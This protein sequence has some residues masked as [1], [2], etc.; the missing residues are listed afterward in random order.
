MPGM[1]LVLRSKDYAAYHARLAAQFRPAVMRGVYA[2]AQR[3]I[4]YLVQRTRAAPPANPN[5]KGSGG[6]VNTGN[7]ARRWRAIRLPDGAEIRND[8]AYGSIIDPE[9]GRYGRRPGAKFPPKPDL[10]AWI[11]RRLLTTAKKPR[12]PSKPRNT[13]EQRRQAADAMR[14]RKAIRSGRALASFK[15]YGPVRPKGPSRRS[16]DLDKQAARL[17]FPIARAIARR[18]LLARRILHDVQPKNDI[19]DFVRAE[20]RRELEKE[21]SRR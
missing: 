1:A 20:V 9:R 12:R 8:A 5:G 6:A 15:K 17:Y 2:G 13:D 21:I 14:I 4:G 10:I 19:L 16:V 18:G 3:S 11:K 7:F